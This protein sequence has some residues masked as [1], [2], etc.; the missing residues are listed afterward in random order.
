MKYRFKIYYGGFFQLGDNDAKENIFNKIFNTKNELINTKN[1]LNKDIDDDSDTEDELIEW[2]HT[3]LKNKIP[4]T[5]DQIK[6]HYL[7]DYMFTIPK[8][9]TNEDTFEEIKEIVKSKHTYELLIRDDNNSFQ[10]ESGTT[11][12]PGAYTRAGEITKISLL[13]LLKDVKTCNLE[14]IDFNDKLAYCLYLS[15]P[16]AILGDSDFRLVISFYDF[17][18]ISAIIPSRLTHTIEPKSIELKI[19]E[20]MCGNGEAT[21][22]FL[23]PILASGINVSKLV[24]TDIIDVN[25]HTKNDITRP[26]IE[27]IENQSFEALNTIDAVKKYGAES[28]VLL[29]FS[30]PPF[31]AWKIQNKKSLE[32]FKEPIGLA[33]F[34]AC[35]DYIKQAR[36]TNVEDK[37]IIIIGELGHSDGTCNIDKYLMNNP[38]LEL[39]VRNKVL[40]WNSS[41]P[42]YQE[43]HGMVYKQ[44]YIFKIKKEN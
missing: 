3:E 28:N 44:L 31:S 21:K 9:F 4:L 10:L 41:Y 30:P 14:N 19:L 8:L 16:Y 6:H 23:E 40:E 1:E 43:E 33:D 39:L 5:L 26:I 42:Y 20:V 29:M 24:Q 32:D 35:H 38:Y 25:T 7:P 15:N 22:Y 11:L 12:S 27:N 37:F 13:Y 34:Y 2:R 36:E 18:K 17:D